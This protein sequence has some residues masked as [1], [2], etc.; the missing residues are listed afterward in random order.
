MSTH[1]IPFPNMKKKT[2]LNKLSQICCYWIFS[3]GLQNEFETAMVNEP[4]EIEPLKFYSTSFECHGP[5]FGS[6]RCKSFK[7]LTGCMEVIYQSTHFLNCNIV[8]LQNLQ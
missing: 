2:I 1:N 8:Q 4:S 6:Q 3:K 5:E 7:L